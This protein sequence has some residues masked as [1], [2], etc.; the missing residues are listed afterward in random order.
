MAAMSIE[1]PE[2]L[3]SR[4]EA[5]ARESGFDS[6]E[7]YVRAVLLADASGGPVIEDEALES[8]LAARQDGP[9][10]DADAADFARM[11]QKLGA[12]LDGP[13]PSGPTGSAP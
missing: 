4:V 8:L 11:R 13:A 12:R 1:L 2:A 10:V 9:F 3:R 5:R 6:V 7:A